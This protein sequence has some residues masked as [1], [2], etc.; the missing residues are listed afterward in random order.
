[1]DIETDALP[2]WTLDD[3]YGSPQAPELTADIKRA[4]ADARAFQARY[5]GTLASLSGDELAQALKAYEGLSDLTGRIG[6]YAG[7][8]YYADM[9]DEAVAAFHQNSMETLNDIGSDLLFFTL[10]LNTLDDAALNARLASS[11][12]LAHYKP[13]LDELRTFRP[14]QLSDDLEQLLHD[15]SVAGRSAWVRLYDETLAALRCTVDGK[16]L[17]LAEVLNLLSNP[18]GEVRR[19]AAQALSA[20][21]K[22]NARL[23]ALVTNTLIKDKEIEDRWRKHATPAES[24][25]LANQVEGEVVEALAK[26]VSDAYPRL[27]HRYYAL[28]ARWMGKEP[29]DYWDRNA[30]LPGDGDEKISWPEARA[31]VLDAYNDFSPRMA[32]IARQF[33][34]KRW[35]DAG[36][37]PGKESGA[38]SHPTVPSAHP[39]VLMNFQGRNRDVMTLAHELGHGVHQ[40]LSAPQGAL[41]AGTPLTLAETASV[42]GEMLTFRS[43]LRRESDPARRRLLIGSKV[44]DMLN[45]VVRQIA[46]HQFE[47][48]LH[49][50]RRTGELSLQRINDIWLETQ[51]ESLGPSIRLGEGYDYLWGYIS[52]FI[53]VPFYVYAYAFGDCLVNSLYAVYEE[54]PEGFEPKYMEMLKAGGTLR[55]KELLAPFGLNAGDPAFWSK[56][57]SVIERFI[58]QLEMELDAQI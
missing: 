41:M 40:V 43:L 26:A 4:A 44:E 30:P 5:K 49:G 56:G 11:A 22:D 6:S 42:F 15:K 16:A 1:M 33:F 34:E 31:M 51:R 23:F 53:H 8:L 50:E 37:R 54:K 14:H 39:Y 52:H 19:K 18:D 2:R 20:T 13:W 25:H 55:H 17:T 57:L 45:T 21:L 28:K 46:F 29:L 35:I 3:L 10:E 32:E 24:R 48:K 27:A 9:S 36:P 7:L 12:G 58:D 47:T 38:F